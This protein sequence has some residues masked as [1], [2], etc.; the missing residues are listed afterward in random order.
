M[1]VSDFIL[2]M[3]LRGLVLTTIA[4]IWVVIL[5][6]VNGLRSFSKMTNFDFVMTVAIGSL[7]AG[8]S[9]ATDWIGFCQ[10]LIAMAM[11]FIVQ[12]TTA[13]IRKASDNFEKLTQNNPVLLMRDGIILHE[14]L[15]KT[16]VAEND[17]IAK[18]REAN[19]LDFSKIRAV[20][21]E[22]TGD[23]SVLH[24][25]HCSDKLLQGTSRIDT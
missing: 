15:R 4:M 12:Y 6:R 11:L 22:T 14:A 7:L 3:L 9:Q 10:G 21:L 18:L 16:R 23:I 25:E 20:V 8:S 1:F 19:V 5:V 2:D 13:R 17:L 24:G